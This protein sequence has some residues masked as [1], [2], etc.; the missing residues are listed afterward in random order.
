MQ[1]IQKNFTDKE[2]NKYKD[3]ELGHV[4]MVKLVPVLVKSIQELSAK[5]KLLQARSRRNGGNLMAL[6]E[7]KFI[8]PA[9]ESNDDKK[10]RLKS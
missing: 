5:V 8:V 1:S 9:T 2:Q 7:Y 6:G 3:D 10:E 4:D